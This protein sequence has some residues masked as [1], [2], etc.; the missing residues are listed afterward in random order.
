MFCIPV[1]RIVAGVREAA[2]VCRPGTLLSD[3][4]SVKSQICAELASGLA[5]GVE[6]VGAHPLA[7]SEKQG[8]ENADPQLFVNRICVVAP[9]GSNTRTAVGRI[10]R[11][12]DRLGANVVELSPEAHDR[13]LAETS[14]LPHL[15][16]AAVAG[17]L[18]PENRDLTA[19]G[20]RDTTRIAAGDVGLW[21]AIFL[22]NREPLLASLTKHERQLAQFRAALEQNDHAALKELLKAAKMNRDGL[23]PAHDLR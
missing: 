18:S 4:G 20:F 15:V 21:T 9:S 19:T 3:A 1:D 16:A 23:S 10:A 8:F 22:Q 11:F 5:P 6:F 14:H 12:W 17:T 7:G 2:S 13:A